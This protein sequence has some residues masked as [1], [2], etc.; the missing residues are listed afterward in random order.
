M[1]DI[2]ILDLQNLRHLIG[3]YENSHC[4]MTDYAS[5]AQDPEVK[6]LFQ[7]AADSAMK[8]KQE[9]MKFL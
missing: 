1:S 2:S 7:D 8:N 3:G 4:K 9:L 6:K 5:Q